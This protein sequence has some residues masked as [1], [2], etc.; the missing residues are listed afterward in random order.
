MIKIIRQFNTTLS[1]NPKDRSLTTTNPRLTLTNFLVLTVPILH[2]PEGQIILQIALWSEIL[3]TTHDMTSNL[4]TQ[5]LDLLTWPLQMK[6][7][8][9]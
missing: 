9:G 7:P 4:T 2:F 1:G 3:T 8:R 6:I 5:S